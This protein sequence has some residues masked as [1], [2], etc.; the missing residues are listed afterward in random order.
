LAHAGCVVVLGFVI[1]GA[2]AA[3]GGWGDTGLVAVLL[4]AGFV[5]FRVHVLA[6]LLRFMVGARLV[7]RGVRQ[8]A[9][10]GLAGLSLAPWIDERFVIGAPLAML[11]VICS[12]R[13]M[14]RRSDRCWRSLKQEFA[15]P[16]ALLAA[17]VVVRL[18][19][20]AGGSAPG[21]TVAVISTR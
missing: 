17:F 1:T 6:G 11:C 13:R 18:G 15:V 7:D 8:V 14:R 12:G 19:V 5:V 2:A 20:L 9:S 10:F 16:G 21:V 4:G 3:W